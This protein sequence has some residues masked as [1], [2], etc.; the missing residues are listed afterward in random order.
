MRICR[1]NDDRLG[2]VRDGLV[3]DVTDALDEL[4]SLR[5]PLPLGDPLIANLEVLAGTLVARA[6]QVG[7]VP[8]AAVSLKSPVAN[9]TKIIGAPVNYRAHLDEALLDDALHHGETVHAIDRLGLFLKAVSALAGPG[10]P[11]HLRFPSRRTDHEVELAVVIGRV[12]SKVSRERALDYVAGYAVGLDLTVRGTEERSM[13]KSIDG[14]AVLGPVLVTADE[15]PHPNNLDLQLSINGELRQHANTRA[16]IF[17]VPKLIELASSFYTL[18][19]G[20]VIMTGTPEGVAPVFPGDRL[21][22]SVES[23]GEFSIVLREDLPA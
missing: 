9:P 10:D 20:D 13:R 5:W 19:P 18:Y 23:L 16:M 11:I 15:V 21:E 4:P 2:V 22:A 12:A 8:L 17:D 14:Y 6:R 1:F 3:Y 7:G